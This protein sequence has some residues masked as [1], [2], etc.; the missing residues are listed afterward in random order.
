[1][2]INQKLIEFEKSLDDYNKG[3][4]LDKITINPEVE[5]VLDL[6]LSIIKVLPK[7]ECYANAFI[8]SEFALFLQKEFNRQSAK[9]KWLEQNLN[10]VIARESNN[11]GDKFTKHEMR[12]ALV[13]ANDE[14]AKVLG[15]H[16]LITSAQ[17]ESLNFLATRVN[18]MAEILTDFAR[19]KRN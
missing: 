1:M 10:N 12:K 6:K 3:Y 7:D 13:I 4:S 14:Y 15:E 17:L 2:T 18:S 5:N 8:L 19:S 11:Y 9:M 16:M